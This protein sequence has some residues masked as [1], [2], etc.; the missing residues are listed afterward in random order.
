MTSSA[1]YAKRLS[2]YENKGKCGLP[3]TEDS[4]RALSMKLNNL[5]KMIKDSKYTVILTGA[6][7]S[8]A[9]GIPDFRG[10]NGIWTCEM[11]E[12]KRRKISTNSDLVSVPKN[13]SSSSINSSTSKLNYV[14]F[15]L[16]RPTITH[17]AITKLVELGTVKF[18]ITQNVDGLHMRS[19]LPRDKHAFLHGCI[20][21]E[22]CRTCGKEFFRNFDIGGVGMKETG[23]KCDAKGCDGKLLDTV[24]DWEDELP[25]EDWNVSQVECAKSDLVISLG[26]SL[27]IEPAG[28][29]PTLSKKYVIVNKQETPYDKKASLVIRAKVD[30]VMIYLMQKLEVKDW[31]SDN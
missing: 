2:E 3:E 13:K 17:R 28:S 31:I 22:K 19:G 4:A 25:E 15:E 12:K 8:T 7:V 10:K 5:L 9:A 30:D 11:R 26:T 24:L 29:L 6:G 20:F 14:P 27:R 21:T 23:R 18:C 1:G 16:A